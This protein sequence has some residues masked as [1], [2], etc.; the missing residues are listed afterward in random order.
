MMFA[1]G[2]LPA[3]FD[4]LTEAWMNTV[5]YLIAARLRNVPLSDFNF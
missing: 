2:Q 5:V 1:S 4:N 3:D